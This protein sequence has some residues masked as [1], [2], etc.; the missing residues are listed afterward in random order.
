MCNDHTETIDKM[1]G[2]AYSQYYCL[3]KS[4]LLSK[5]HTNL[6]FTGWTMS[7]YVGN[8]TSNVQSHKEEVKYSLKIMA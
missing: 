6:H 7:A 8:V 2:L 5:L 4:V 3:P 1:V